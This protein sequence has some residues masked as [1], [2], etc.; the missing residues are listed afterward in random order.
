MGR[1]MG[2]PSFPEGQNLLNFGPSPA[3]LR[4]HTPLPR[5]I[6][7]LTSYLLIHFSAD[8]GLNLLVAPV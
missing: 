3:P 4:A 2:L 6:L 8:I 5:Y 1:V 7:W